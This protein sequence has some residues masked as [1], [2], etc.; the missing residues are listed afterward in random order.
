MRA[1]D[2]FPSPSSREEAIAAQRRL[3]DPLTALS[4]DDQVRAVGHSLLLF[5]AQALQVRVKD[6]GALWPFVLN[7]IQRRYRTSLRKR[8]LQDPRRGP[9]RFRGIRDLIV[10]PRQLGFST[11]IASLFFDDGLLNPGRVS[12]ILAHDRDIAEILLETYRLFW[13]HL[14]PSL[15]AGLQLSSDTKYEFEIV[16][17]GDQT[18]NPPSKFVIDTEAG[19]PW[20]G[21]VIH[22]LHAC[23]GPDTLVIG[24]DGFV[25]P[26][27]SPPAMVRDGC[28]SMISVQSVAETPH[29]GEA[30]LR[31][32]TF[33]NAPFPLTL[34][35]DHRVL[36]REFKT[37]KPVWKRA[38]ELTKGDYIGFPI[39]KMGECRSKVL[40]V[41]HRKNC[42]HVP[43]TVDADRGL[44]ALI[45][46][47]LAEGWAF[48]NGD[49][50]SGIGLAIHRDETAQVMAVVQPYVDAGFFTSVRVTD[51]A[52]SW[53][54]H[55][56]LHGGSFADL[57][58]GL[59]GETDSKRIPDAFFKYPRPF[60]EGLL[61][62]LIEGDGSFVDPSRVSFCTT[63][64][65]LAVQL[66][67]LAI[68][69]RIGLPS[70][71]ITDAGLRHGRREQD[72]WVVDFFGPANVKLRRMLGKP[73]PPRGGMFQAYL[74][75]RPD[76][77]R[78]NH[79]YGRHSWR[80]G[81]KYYW[82]QVKQI[83][84]VPAP[85]VMY[86]LCLSE[87][88]HSYCTLSG[89]V[90]NSEAAFYRDYQGF[91]NSY[92][93]AV[94]ASGNAILETTANGQNLYYSDVM[95]ALE[96]EGDPSMPW[97]VVYYAWFEH[98]EYRRPFDP[99]TQAPLSAE[100]VALMG[101]HGLDLQQIAW[102]RAKMREVGE[103]FPQEY[104]ETL[105]GA[106][107]TSG[108]PYFDQQVVAARIEALQKHPV[109]SVPGPAGSTIWEPYLPGETYLLV[110]DIA[111][112]IDRGATR[113]GDPEQGGT[114]FCSAYVL[115]VRTLRVVAALHGRIPP[116]EFAR[117]M[118]TLGRAYR[119]C[120]APERNNH[121]HTVVHVLEE[122]RY[123]E[124]YRHLEYDA[125]GARFL[126]AGF[127]TDTK[128]RPMILDALAEVIRTGQLDCP[129]PRFWLEALRFHRNALGKP[130]A[131][132]GAHDDR[133]MS[134]AIGVYLATLG[135]S[136]W[137]LEGV[138]G[139]DRAGFPT[140]SALPPAGALEAPVAPAAPP[141]ALVPG[142]HPDRLPV[143][144][145]TGGRDLVAEVAQ[146]RAVVRR[147]T[148]GDCMHYSEALGGI[149]KFPGHGF[150]VKAADPSCLAH[151]PAKGGPTDGWEDESGW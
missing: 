56:T 52:N 115:R 47:Y 151:Y 3:L 21:G 5:C 51:R 138:E 45:G 119:A 125:A 87:D 147:R 106:F 124:V 98:P 8:H 122:A 113:V 100:E 105:A 20:R 13:D 67:R 116:V 64:P 82:A 33:G 86:D 84:E 28:G 41:P 48:R 114:D 132:P 133:V 136:G 62:G 22:N 111:E 126:R 58:V 139:S 123:P 145:S 68:N 17:P 73:L 129:D 75:K 70:I 23:L 112:G 148:C 4:E 89:V 95:A 38:D 109:S 30:A 128:T 97:R 102:R 12:V 150:R 32:T 88:P 77:P 44:G 91:K 83:E 92:L 93:Q 31:V 94:P 137:G 46:W 146:E 66:K 50:L 80:R 27:A 39:T 142:V 108:R 9:D 18:L 40:D 14:P 54:T 79:G 81:D 49:L 140:L 85:P 107:L 149:C 117:R 24:K 135:R 69:M 19:H 36:T 76:S 34:T 42:I 134:L 65:Q 131:L 103:T 53:T 143:S 96:Q 72:R 141:A 74:D 10:K 57:V 7:P 37:G 26:I 104:P 61:T 127:P 120:V 43:A 118:D 63:R 2:A 121:G 11:F 55:I 1:L 99:A 15:K 101:A 35:R 90:H 130:E 60:L 71:Q 78:W 6:G 29:V 144:T 16:F 110:A 25:F 59:V